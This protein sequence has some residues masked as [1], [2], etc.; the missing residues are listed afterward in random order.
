MSEAGWLLYDGGC[1]FCCGLADSWGR[2]AQRAGFSLAELQAEWVCER[3]ARNGEGTDA[4]SDELLLLL[5]DDHVLGGADAL[6][7]ICSHIWW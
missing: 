6:V 3:L 4:T 5:P 1:D 2:L 7:E